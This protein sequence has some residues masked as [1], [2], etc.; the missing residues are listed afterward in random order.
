MHYWLKRP[1]CKIYKI[2]NMCIIAELKKNLFKSAYELSKNG[3]VLIR[4]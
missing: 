3:S 2:I 1:K 4:T